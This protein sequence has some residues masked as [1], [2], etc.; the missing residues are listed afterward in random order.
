MTESSIEKGNELKLEND[1][2]VTLFDKWELIYGK[3]L[4]K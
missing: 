2:I 1:R 3:S 4:P